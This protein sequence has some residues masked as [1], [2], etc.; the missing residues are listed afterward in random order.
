MNS[1]EA[2]SFVQ[3]CE[4]L[5]RGANAQT[6]G[7]LLDFRRSPTAINTALE[8]IS[9]HSCSK[10]V[11]FQASLLL[12]NAAVE[13]W[14]LLS[15]GDRIDLRKKLLEILMNSSH[16]R[17]VW[18]QLV[19]ALAILWKRGWFDQDQGVVQAKND[20]FSHIKSMLTPSQGQQTGMMSRSV[21]GLRLLISLVEEFSSI[22][23]SAIGLP[24][25]FHRECH[26]S[27]EQA[28]LQEAFNMGTMVLNSLGV[29]AT[30][31]G[32]GPWSAQDD[33]LLRVCLELME[34]C[35]SWDFQSGG[36]ATSTFQRESAMMF[37]KMHVTLRTNQK[38]CPGK[39]WSGTLVDS[40]LIDS[41]FGLYGAVRSTSVGSCGSGTKDSAHLIRQ[42]LILLSG[43]NGNVFSGSARKVAYM[44]TMIRGSLFG[45]LR[46]PLVPMQVAAGLAQTFEYEGHGR[47]SKEAMCAAGSSEYLDMCTLLGRLVSNFGPGT[48]SLLGDFPSFADALRNF[49]ELLMEGASICLT[50]PMPQHTNNSISDENMDD[51]DNSW[52]MEAFGHLLEAWV[53]FAS[54]AAKAKDKG[55]GSVQVIQT[56]ASLL[57]C[58]YV[59]RRLA[60]A[61]AS[62]ERETE[63]NC[64][65]DDVFEDGS[66]LEEHLQALAELGRSDVAN[67]LS[68]MA[69]VFQETQGKLE[70][71]L[72]APYSPA[73]VS[74]CGKLSEEMFWITLISS[75]LLA[76][77]FEGEQPLIPDSILRLCTETSQQNRPASENPA[78]VL[79]WCLLKS[80]DFESK[81]VR[82]S[83]GGDE[84]ISPL[85][86][87]KLLVSVTR[88]AYSYLVPE[89][90]LYSFLSNSHPSIHS[91]PPRAVDECFG[92]NEQGK[93]V[94]EFL[95]QAASVYL[96]N[97]SLEASVN[98]Q[99][100]A[101]LCA[102][103]DNGG[104]RKMLWQVPSWENVCKA[105]V[106]ACQ[107]S[108]WAPL[109]GLAANS[110]GGL[111][112]LLLRSLEVS[113][114]SPANVLQEAYARFQALTSPVMMALERDAARVIGAKAEKNIFSDL[115]WS[116][117]ID[118]VVELY[119]GILVASTQGV[120]GRWGREFLVASLPT[121]W[122]DVASVAVASIGA[123]DPNSDACATARQLASSCLKLLEVYCTELLCTTPDSQLEPIL[124]ACARMISV[125]SEYHKILQRR[126]PCDS[127]DEEAW[128]C[129]VLLVLKILSAVSDRE[130]M[131]FAEADPTEQHSNF[132]VDGSVGV[133]LA[134]GIQL[135]FPLITKELLQYPSI[136]EYFYLLLKALTDNHPGKIASL[137]VAL[138]Q[139]V[140]HALEFGIMDHRI[141]A[142]RRSF[143]A[144]Y[145]LA[146]F[147]AKEI[148]QSKPGLSQNLAQTS[149]SEGS[150]FLILL[151]QVFTFLV[152][153]TFD[154]SLLRPASNAMLALII[155]EQQNFVPLV[156]RIIST[157][158]APELRARL[159]EAFQKL[160]SEN[161]VQMMLDNVNRGRFEKNVVN[162]VNELRG[163]LRKR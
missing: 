82:A 86:S 144:V 126:P 90:S 130:L 97:W 10:Y 19:Q 50:R 27:F 157:Q 149:G 93:Q 45:V 7:L 46:Q 111:I 41:L 105:H 154:S 54:W 70:N 38:I 100:L 76:D 156:E 3:V 85:L 37:S 51:I 35:L 18:R 151:Q 153:Q 143:E 106:E 61:R 36:N 145:K 52:L 163:F 12:K 56:N 64:F 91:G 62:M 58:T 68:L 147:H 84:R 17:S 89:S 75:N 67:S 122:P 1:S 40:N 9:S 116:Q 139:P 103:V 150:V 43:L 29:K 161:D 47:E 20:L 39:A 92:L 60:I 57:F 110:H 158:E 32:S 146:A 152:F 13:Q 120:L 72:M 162:F 127:E 21:I 53:S 95:V 5:Q 4:K 131:D 115:R 125:Y 121:V 140:V 33:E 102:L 113:K 104:T 22:K 15:S 77:P 117:N 8:L 55:Q 81:R 141:E 129:D 31:A 155:C 23:A 119:H 34:S 132:D 87:E 63:D 124:S 65:E 6:E 112:S 101:L 123:L 26:S 25:G 99:A 133:V 128:A 148:A 14:S 48:F 98:T 71:C 159:S 108:N 11:K 96:S 118:R 137:G 2:I 88:W 79:S 80:L 109:E 114:D 74:E 24:F 30:A 69:R 44:E 134:S 28:G 135:C 94:M 107:S 78:I 59:A 138:F 73:S 66:V 142:S 42:L 160:V 49:A 16:D 83:K 136:A